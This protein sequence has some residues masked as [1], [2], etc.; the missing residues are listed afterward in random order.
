MSDIILENLKKG[1]NSPTQ[2]KFL[3]KSSDHI[4]YQ[5]GQNV[6]GHNYGCQRAIQVENNITNKDGYT[7]TIFNLDGNHPIW[8]N[9]VQM[10]PKQMKI[11]YSSQEKIV[12]HGYG[13]DMFGGAFANYG[14]SIHCENEKV[15]KCVLHM[16]DRSV[17]IEYFV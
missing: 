8:Q 16:Y 5:N 1:N 9:N 13:H 7:V 3:F 6:S 4:R 17:D 2:G 14:L 12:L 11:I 10:S 15:E